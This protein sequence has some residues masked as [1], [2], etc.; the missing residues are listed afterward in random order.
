[1]SQFTPLSKPKGKGRLS[2]NEILGGQIIP[3]ILRLR[4]ISEDDFEDLVLE[5]VDGF[6]NKKYV[7]IRRYG[8]AG[9]KGRDVVGFYE[10]GE[11]DIFQC[12]HYNSLLSPAQFWVELGKLCFYTFKGFYPIPNNYYI[13]TSRGIGPKLLDYID[14]PKVFNQ[15]LIDNWKDKCQKGIKLGEVPL[16]EKLKKHIQDFD[17][18]IVQDKPPLELINEHKMTTHYPQR[19]GGGLVK[20]RSEIPKPSKKVTL[21]ELNYT[22]LLFDAYSSKL[23]KPISKKED[24]EA[25]DKDLLE[26]FK[27]E[28]S[29]FY[30]TE[31]LERFSRDNFSDLTESP[32]SEMKED[33]LV[34]IKTKLRLSTFIEPFDRLED[35]KLL[36][37]SQGFSSNPLHKEIRNLDKLGMCHYLANENKIKWRK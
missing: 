7:K 33:S 11:L 14:K 15:L 28:R 32:F 8:G 12:K 36:M 30:C 29:S 5:W 22:E 17:F 34:A 10:N 31:S 2:T 25:L 13:V 9:D 24:I 4:N 27:D 1:M 37:L 6:L 21:R 18:S 35:A 3:P 26:H 19:F 23:N 16:S 20:Y